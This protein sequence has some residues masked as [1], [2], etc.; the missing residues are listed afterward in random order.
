[1]RLRN[2]KG[3]KDEIA[4]SEYV[5]HEPSA[6][7]GQW[8][9]FFGNT[10]P[11]HIEIGMG[12]GKFLTT[13]ALMN[14]QINYIGIERYES[15]LIRALEKRRT[16]DC[17]NIIFLCCDAALIETIFAPGEID[18][19]YLNFS[20]PWPKDRHARRR[21]TS[22][23]F[24]K[25]YD[26]IL[27]PSGTVEFKTDNKPLF[28]FSLEQAEKNQWNLS[29]VSRDYHSESFACN[30]VMTEYEEKFSSEG[31]SICHMTISRKSCI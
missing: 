28:E 25:R 23:E 6:L 22:E 8:N 15:V 30:N 2:I 16:I 31:N 3:A 4:Q 26:S 12:K 27:I 18:K 5:V 29:E 13:L 17:P 19:I 9:N 1:M 10:N 14:P 20:D 7:K 21:L 11:I 24:L